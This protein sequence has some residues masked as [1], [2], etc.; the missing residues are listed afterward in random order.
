VNP[1]VVLLARA[2]SAK[3]KTRLTAHL[4]ADR[5]LALRTA[6]FLDTLD[7]VC[8]TALPVIVSFTPV[9]ARD[10]MS[11]LV[12]DA[13]LVPQVG[14]GLGERMHRAIDDGLAAGFDAVVL[15]GSDLPTLPA[16]YIYDAI[17]QLKGVDGIR[18]PPD[19][20][21]GPS[22]DGGFY[23]VGARHPLPDIFRDVPWDGPAVLR[24]VVEA[25]RALA[26]RVAFTPEWWDVDKPEDLERLV[27]QS[28]ASAP[29]AACDVGTARRLREFLDTS[30]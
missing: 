16:S 11:T 30:S 6:L 28:S 24:S 14:V 2:P 27:R 21:L 22:E 1:V 19:L 5:A 26:L 20:I 25:A 29:G 9:D 4:P 7:V 18:V 17:A 15:I 3:G 12:P 8:A 10:E 23:L 13:R